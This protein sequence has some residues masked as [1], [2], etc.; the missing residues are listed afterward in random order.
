MAGGLAL[1]GPMLAHLTPRQTIAVA[2]LAAVAM[3]AVVAVPVL[4]NVRGEPHVSGVAGMTVAPE[5]TMVG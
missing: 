3:V 5:G 1:A 2:G 4:R